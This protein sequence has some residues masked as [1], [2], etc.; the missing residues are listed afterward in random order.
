MRFR[1]IG[2]SD[3]RIDP[4]GWLYSYIAILKNESAKIAEPPSLIP[5]Y[6]RKRKTAREVQADNAAAAAMF[7][8]DWFMRRE[9]GVIY[10]HSYLCAI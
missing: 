4:H 7:G 8:L 9:F 10:D 3:V 2:G 6:G 1:F 5:A